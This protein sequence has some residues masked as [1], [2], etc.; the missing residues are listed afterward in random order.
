MSD[1]DVPGDL[2]PEQR[3]L[4]AL[5]RMRTQLDEMRAARSEPIAIVGMGCRF[6]GGGD[7]PEA[8]WRLLD[9]GIDAVSVVPRERWDADAYFDP[10]PA[11]PGRIPS[12]WGGFLDGIDGFDPMFFGLSPREAALMDPQHRMLLEV[13]H[14]AL[15]DA[16]TSV[17]EIAGSRTGVFVG[18]YNSDYMGLLIRETEAEMH[19]GTGTDAAFGAGRVAFV[20]D[21]KGPCLS[22]NTQCSSSLVALHLAVQS[23]RS[24]ETDRAIAGG[25]NVIIDPAVQVINARLGT[26]SPTGRCRTFDAEADGIV[27]GEGCGIVV[28]KR[29]SDALA[30]GDRVF[31]LV[32]GTAVNQDGRSARLTAPSGSAQVELMRAALEQAGLAP[33]QVSYIQTH[34]TGT[35]LGDPIE[36]DA[37]RR[38]YGAPRPAGETCAL[39]SV[40]TNLGH[41]EAAAGI[42]GLITAVLALR[43][44]RIPP[45]LHF[46]ALN[47]HIS[48]E[49]S[50]FV[51]P[52]EGLPW[53]AGPEP[54]R[55]AVSAFGM[56]G[57]NAH[58]I[59]EEPP[60]QGVASVS[61][62]RPWHLLTLSA[63]SEPALEALAD[64]WIERAT[65][66]DAASLADLAYSANTG[67]SPHTHR[68]TVV[69]R[70]REELPEA[71]GDGGDGGGG[72]PRKGRARSPRPKV[73]FLF[74]GQGAQ[75][76]GMGRQLYETSPTFRASLERS[77]EILRPRLEHPLLDVIFGTAPETG[78]IDD[79]AYAQPALVALE[80]ALAEIWRAFGV[81]PDVVIGHSVGEYA[82]AHVAGAFSLEDALSL[83]AE[84]GRLMSALPRDGAMW[85]IAAP[86]A[87]VLDALG[88]LGGVVSVAAVNGPSDT[89]VSGESEAAERVARRFEGR[90]SLVRRLTVSHAFH[91]P[92]MDP[93]LDAF[94][95][96]ARAVTL[97]EPRIPL[98]SNL[99]GGIADLA[100]LGSTS[101]WRRHVR[102]AVR[103]LDGV[104]HLEEMEVRQLVEIG[105]KPV[106]LGMAARCLPPGG[107]TS[108]PSL[109]QGQDDWR[110]LLESA[111][112]L[113]VEGA[114]LDRRGLDA[115]Y[116]RRRVAIPTYPY[117]RER[118]WYR[119]TGG[120]LRAQ[121]ERNALWERRWVPKPLER[122]KGKGRWLV[123]LDG[124]W[125]GADL[126]LELA[127]RGVDVLTAVP[128][129]GFARVSEHS[130]E[131]DPGSKSDWAEVLAEAGPLDGVVHNFALDSRWRGAASAD[132]VMESARDVLGSALG[133]AQAGQQ[134]ASP[135]PRFVFVTEGA[136]PLDSVAGADPVQTAL[137]GFCMALR[138]EEPATWGGIVDLAPDLEGLGALA[139]E[140]LGPDGEDMVALRRDGRRVFRL[141]PATAE[142]VRELTIPEDATWLITGG[143]GA[144][145]FAIT[146]MLVGLGVRRFV[147][148]GRSAPNEAAEAVL[149]ELRAMGAEIVVSLGDVANEADTAS[150][151][152][153]AGPALHGIVHSAGIL[154][155]CPLRTEDWAHV[156]EVLAPKVAG[157]FHLDR[158]SRR[159]APRLE[160]FILL[161]S[162]AST[163]GSVGDAAYG[164]ANA[165]LDGLAHARRAEGLP[166]QTTCWSL[167]SGGGM[168]EHRA[169]ER[170]FR[171]VGVTPL[172]VERGLSTLRRVIESDVAE[173]TIIDIDWQKYVDVLN[174]R[175]PLLSDVADLPAAT[176]PSGI[177][178]Q[179]GEIAGLE[180]EALRRAEPAERA[181]ILAG[182]LTSAVALALGCRPGDIDPERSLNTMGLDSIVGLELQAAIETH[183]H[184]TVPVVTILDGPSVSD[185]T[186]HILE[187]MESGRPHV[188]AS[189]PVPGD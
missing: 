86:E 27:R 113:W 137:W 68:L 186:A 71:L 177:S 183:L 144:L 102:E 36:V 125:R 4:V 96:S 115:D 148:T 104:R 2:A 163:V 126:A 14:E 37:L 69:A 188:G 121:P 149:R 185:L 60:E 124:N 132:E 55:A 54:R 159:S 169:V 24:R 52:V 44:E 153:E 111:G 80:V 84:R 134:L 105:P 181:S 46:K 136:H 93:M 187:E 67:R 155:T 157:G 47:P 70:T 10:D 166:A 158:L 83:V 167:W 73:A 76:V 118:Y 38:V 180:L 130:F 42:A 179:K 64:R 141:A 66:P 128:A 114:H 117:Q 41:L 116:A 103:F 35:P 29:L 120:A 59:L 79:T 173:L 142:A 23:L 78:S 172:S 143:M 7:D 122:A 97:L 5:R 98:V 95:G 90:G 18:I 43:H 99:T 106:L 57:T 51:I 170:R 182:W 22:I 85:A 138:L 65:A 150:A 92:L 145:G 171:E 123:S 164:A 135:R 6:P 34:G 9:E 91:S 81:E 56:S 39:G 74:T 17:D 189:A 13:T 33:E 15:E 16:G 107:Q 87:E 72:V 119:R 61:V 11:T 161:S 112:A 28:L 168:G 108:L 88:E 109:R 156:S 100:L 89:V 31:G 19:T 131:L 58:L 75:H 48:L 94:E 175:S 40:K 1:H 154:G 165:W 26:L 12:R 133:L 62:D 110:V 53:S 140:L 129:S 30:S 184:V 176:A 32:R 82:A 101:Y 50:P 20:F 8:F 178:E 25:V 147:L 45:H 63:H 162:A 151:L 77:A 152:A 127:S 3:A 160:H 139:D 49:G 21:L 174:L 146:R